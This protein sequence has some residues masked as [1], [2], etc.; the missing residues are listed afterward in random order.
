MYMG[1]PIGITVE[2]ANILTRSMIIF[3]QGAVRCHPWA[4]DEMIAAQEKDGAKFDRALWGHFGHII[5]N[6]TR[7]LLLSLTRG[8]LVRSPVSGPAARYWRRLSWS[9][10][11]FAILSDIAMVGLGGQLK[12]REKL[13]GR[14]ADI[15]S[16][17][18]LATAA[19]RRFEADGR[20]DTDV[21]LMKWSLEMC[22]E[23]IQGAF[24]GLYANY[25]LPVIGTF[26]RRVVAPWSRLNSLGSGPNDRL[27]AA[28]ASA[29]RDDTPL[30]TRLTSG[31]HVPT[32]ESEALGRLERAYQAASAA[33]E[34]ITKIKAA[35]RDG[36]LKKGSAE[37]RVDAAIEAEVIDREAGVAVQEA[38]ALR[39][40]LIQVDSFP[41]D[42]FKSHVAVLPPNG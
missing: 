1:V 25:P 16:W 3:G 38:A 31:L 13:T 19:L 40:D 35:M 26:F 5:R 33:A 9:S 10:A 17:M 20:R 12:R 24:D 7:A 4:L 22:F 11:S 32:A 36:R 42:G 14:F 8:W 28:A 27:G 6:S 37:L 18:Y 2:G 30:R 21:G 41:A 39:E 34:S 23:R 29:L 15:L